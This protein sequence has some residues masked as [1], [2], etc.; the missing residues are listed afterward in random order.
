MSASSVRYVIKAT[1]FVNKPCHVS[2]HSP[3]VRRYSCTHPSSIIHHPSSIQPSIHPLYILSIHSS[4]YWLFYPSVTH[5]FL[6]FPM[7][8]NPAKSRGWDPEDQRSPNVPSDPSGQPTLTRSTCPYQDHHLEQWTCTQPRHPK[9]LNLIVE[10]GS[11]SLG[12]VL[13]LCAFNHLWFNHTVM[14]SHLEY[15]RLF[16]VCY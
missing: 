5:L 11:G 2:T 9:G 10:N 7:T 4:T 1:V 12:F 8:R 16:L 3:A 6:I 15:P 13:I 14:S